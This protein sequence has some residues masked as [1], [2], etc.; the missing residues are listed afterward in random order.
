M[1]RGLWFWEERDWG[2]EELAYW[3]LQWVLGVR[4]VRGLRRGRW[5]YGVRGGEG[6][7]WVAELRLGEEDID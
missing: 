4:W 1:R 7:G 5:V 3:D 2:L 6:L